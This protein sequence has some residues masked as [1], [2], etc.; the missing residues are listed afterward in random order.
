MIYV[1]RME[2][3]QGTVCV[4]QKDNGKSRQEGDVAVGQR[5]EKLHSNER[6]ERMWGNDQVFSLEMLC[7]SQ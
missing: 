4:Q 7:N 3:T 6:E 5:E 1:G 2:N